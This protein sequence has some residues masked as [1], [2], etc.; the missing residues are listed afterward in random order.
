V[1][2]PPRIEFPCSYPIKVMGENTPSLRD[3]VLAVFAQLTELDLDV[4]VTERA[5]G[6]GRFVSVTVTIIATGAEQLSLLHDRLRAVPGV[7]LVL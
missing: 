1:S 3:D 4:P 2:E 7:K 5:S 6:A